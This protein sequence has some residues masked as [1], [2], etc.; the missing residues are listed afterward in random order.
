M[1]ISLV[2][3]GKIKEKYLTEGIAEFTKRLTPY[4]KLETIAIGVKKKC[5]IIL[6]LPKKSRCWLKK[7]SV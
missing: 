4:C 1:K 3:V 6:R 7:R 2:C 5:R